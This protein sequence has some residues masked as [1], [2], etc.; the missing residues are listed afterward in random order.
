MCIQLSETSTSGFVFNSKGDRNQLAALGFATISDDFVKDLAKCLHVFPSWFCALITI[1]IAKLKQNVIR[2]NWFKF[3]TSF[4]NTV[5]RVYWWLF[6]ESWENTKTEL[7]S[8]LHM[9]EAVRI[10]CI[11][12]P[13]ECCTN[14]GPENKASTV[15]LSDN[16]TSMLGSNVKN[17]QR[18]FVLITFVELVCCSICQRIKIQLCTDSI[19]YLNCAS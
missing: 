12:N 15:H 9:N 11:F 1:I 6:T 13:S 18:N 2:P 4:T 16:Y 17:S 8:N 5:S 7:N 14:S 19:P 10:S 3:W